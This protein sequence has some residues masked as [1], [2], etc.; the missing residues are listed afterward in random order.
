MQELQDQGNPDQVFLYV[1]NSN[2][3]NEVQQLIPM[4]NRGNSRLRYRVG[5]NYDNFVALKRTPSRQWW[6]NQSNLISQSFTSSDINNLKTELP[7]YVTAVEDISQP[8][9][10]TKWWGIHKEKLPG[11]ANAYKTTYL[12]SH[13]LQQKKEFFYLNQHF[14]TT[15]N[16]YTRG[17]HVNF[18]HVTVQ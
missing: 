3:F 17:L 11:W 6:Q 10:L 13:S 7:F 2:V 12:C 8:V 15:A 16:F 14:S 18:C 1:N 9:D 5:I 4:K